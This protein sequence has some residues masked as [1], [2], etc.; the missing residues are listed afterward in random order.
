M[1]Y[2]V[3]SSAKKQQQ[4]HMAKNPNAN[5]KTEPNRIHSDFLPALPDVRRI[6]EFFQFAAWCATPQWDRECKT[7]KEFAEQVRVDEDTLT[8]WKKHPDFWS[9]VWQLVSERLKEQI[10]DVIDG[11]YQKIISAKGGAADVQLFLRLA[12]GE[13]ADKKTK[14][15]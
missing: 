9:L 11:L 4:K 10:P 14:N 7:Q 15:K 12:Q 2:K 6:P 13:P 3:V 8:G 5:I 1:P